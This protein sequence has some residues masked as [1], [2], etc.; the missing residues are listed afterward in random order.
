MK[1]TFVTASH[2]T[3][4]ETEV[5]EILTRTDDKKI[6]A[7]VIGLEAA[8]I[9]S[10]LK[11]QDRKLAKAAEQ[12]TT[13]A[14]DATEVRKDVARLIETVR[15]SFREVIVELLEPY[16]LRLAEHLGVKI[17]SKGTKS[18]AMKTKTASKKTA[19]TRRTKTADLKVRVANPKA[20]SRI[21]PQKSRKKPT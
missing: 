6:V 1:H 2:T 7:E 4:D 3:Y 10:K 9:E 5:V 20:K 18:K 17:P 12:A 11:T 15:E 8:D 21:A 19:T 14:K 16:Y 13:A